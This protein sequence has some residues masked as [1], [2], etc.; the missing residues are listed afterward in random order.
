MYPTHC[1]PGLNNRIDEAG[2]K[3]ALDAAAVVRWWISG[4]DPVRGPVYEEPSFYLRLR[5]WL[6]S[7]EPQ[8]RCACDG[9]V[10]F[11]FGERRFHL[12]SASALV[13]L[14]E[15]RAATQLREPWRVVEHL[16]RALHMAPRRFYHEID[17]R[18]AAARAERAWYDA[19]P[20]C[21]VPGLARHEQTAL[22]RTVR[23]ENAPADE[24]LPLLAA[25][26]PERE[27]LV[28]ALLGWLGHK[29]QPDGQLL[30]EMLPQDLLERAGAADV[31]AGYDWARAPERVLLGAGAYLWHRRTASKREL[32]DVPAAGWD[33]IV[34]AAERGGP[35]ER[36]QRFAE[37]RALADAERV[38]R[39]QS[40]PVRDARGIWT[41][42]VADAAWI[43]SVCTDGGAVYAA[44]EG[45]VVRV[46]KGSV[47]PAVLARGAAGMTSLCADGTTV[48]VLRGGR[49]DAPAPGSLARVPRDGGEEVVLTTGRLWPHAPAVFRGQL[50]WFEAP[51]DPA[52]RD[53]RHP[54]RRPGVLMRLGSDGA[55]AEVMRF[56]GECDDM[57][58]GAERLAWMTWPAEGHGRVMLWDGA[59]ARP[60]TLAAVREIT[61]RRDASPRIA[62][63][64]ADVLWIDAARGALMRAP[65]RGGPVRVA[66]ESALPIQAVAARG[67][68]VWLVTGPHD[69]R[70][71][72]HVERVDPA[73]CK[74]VR[75]AAFE[76]ERTS[77]L[78][79]CVA[80]D[81][82][83]WNERDALLGLPLAASDATPRP[84]G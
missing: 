32:A 80:A 78:T 35:G 53:A 22:A 50:H 46:A 12:C 8:W 57:T 33:A 26:Y 34:A 48:Y 23:Q 25:V 79:L 56:E 13:A 1:G 65:V 27:A 38:R 39:A 20:A 14:D 2:F 24:A 43:G 36:A 71:E 75:V 69:A 37:G 15:D 10:V 5:L 6:A 62:L 4:T 83:Y 66:C 54:G 63:G 58:A 64:A 55:P 49:L 77:K 42:A 29:A 76:H 19:A 81:A 3:R 72:W 52:G 45:A 51:P 84:F 68:E 60:T 28:T 16:E 41:V 7:W 18:V 73:A 74:A 44:S 47:R 9:Q 21:L 61:P 82:V 67:E 31:L 40:A 59:A 17:D 70:S 11:M 30:R